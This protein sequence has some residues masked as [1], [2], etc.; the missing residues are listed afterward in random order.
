MNSN[1]KDSRNGVPASLKLHMRATETISGYINPI[2]DLIDNPIYANES[3]VPQ[4]RV[5][6]PSSGM[7][8]HMIN[9]ASGRLLPNSGR[10]GSII[11]AIIWMIQNTSV[12]IVLGGNIIVSAIVSATLTM[13]SRYPMYV[14]WLSTKET[15]GDFR[16]LMIP[17]L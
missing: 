9:D 8:Q 12:H 5:G 4:S 14:G 6:P 17:S 2:G 10:L 13:E 15:R 3:Q 1:V 16:I 11:T 7:K